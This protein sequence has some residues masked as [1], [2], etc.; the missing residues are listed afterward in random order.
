MFF[1]LRVEIRELA[2]CFN[3]EGGGRRFFLLPLSPTLPPE[4]FPRRRALFL[5]K[6]LMGGP[7]DVTIKKRNDGVINRCILPAESP[8]ADA[9]VLIQAPPPP[10]II[11]IG[12]IITETP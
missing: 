7:D 12:L 2:R 11:L 3:G 5:P 1:A 9:T 4:S 6:N 8:E 10:R